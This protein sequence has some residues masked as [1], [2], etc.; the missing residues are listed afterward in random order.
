MLRNK[1]ARRAAVTLFTIG[2]LCVGVAGPASAADMADFAATSTGSDYGLLALHSS[3]LG[4][5]QSDRPVGVVC[6]LRDDNAPIG[7]TILTRGARAPI[8]VAGQTRFRGHS[9][10]P[11]LVDQ[12][13]SGKLI[14]PDE[15]NVTYGERHDWA[16]SLFGDLDG[17]G[18]PT[19]TPDGKADYDDFAR[20]CGFNEVAPAKVSGPDL[21]V[22]KKSTTTLAGGNY[23]F[24]A[25]KVPENSTLRAAPGS[26][27]R[28][29]TNKVTLAE[30]ATIDMPGWDIV[31]LSDTVTIGDSA[32]A[33][34]NFLSL[35]KEMKVGAHA[36]LT[37][38]FCGDKITL[39]DLVTVT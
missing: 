36:S 1:H 24:S 12:V 39:A 13:Y 25:V 34:G 30:N 20:A 33:V 21:N 4:T 26:T 14:Q 38:R 7:V 17:D 15:D 5:V 6:Q 2:A 35:R 3:K 9:A 27:G 23:V 22:G 16:G 10:A 29:L 18:N 28:I 11:A 8:V 32:R 37:G 31:A 19:C